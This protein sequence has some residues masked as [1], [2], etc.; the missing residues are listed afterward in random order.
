[1]ESEHLQQQLAQLHAELADAPQ[2]DPQVRELLVKVMA[3]I[4]PLVERPPA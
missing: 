1:M 2:I 4:A 3:D